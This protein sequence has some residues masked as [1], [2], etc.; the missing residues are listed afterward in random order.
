MRAAPPIL[1][2][3]PAPA[4]RQRIERVRGRASR[5]AD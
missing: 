4:S 5:A 3:A 2:T 1:P